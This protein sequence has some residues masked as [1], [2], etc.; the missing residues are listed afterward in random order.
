MALLHNFFFGKPEDWKQWFAA[1]MPGLEVRF[2]PEAGNR[3][4]IDVIACGWLPE[5]EFK[6]FPNLRLII[7]LL[8]GP[9]HLLHDPAVPK[10]VPI[11]RAG[12]PLGDTMMNEVTLLHV[13]RHHRN[14]PAYAAAQ[15]RAEWVNLPRQPARERKVGV[16]GLGVIG[17]AAAKMLKGIG[18]Q[19]AGW[20][21][22]PR[23]PVDGIE[24]FAGREQ[25]GA[26]LARSDILV[27][28]L[29]LTT[30]TED[31]LNAKAFSALPNGAAVINLGRGG[32]LVEKDLVAA[33]DS[34]HLAAATLDV[35]RQEPLPKEDP[36]WRHPRI[37]I[38]PHASRR[39]EGRPMVP[40]ICDAVRRL[41]AGKPL[42][43]LI[44]R[45]KG[46]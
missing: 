36:L 45:G 9:D 43:N 18:F 31:I 16:M 15:Q 13:L 35:F 6:T 23:Q 38:M 5:G 22:T 40:R 19:V 44:D 2:W 46:Y 41:H 1:E 28:L 21:R 27:N 17:L 4:D 11:V 7:S 10:H 25:L 33:L 20:V 14:M 12:D 26:F 37:T 32:H 42:E 3:A 29:P 8:A 39:I 30:E 24:V 34:G